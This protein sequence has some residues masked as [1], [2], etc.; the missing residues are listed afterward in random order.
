MMVK[1]LHAASRIAAVL[2][3]VG[4][5]VA[6]VLGE[7]VPSP[8]DRHDDGVS[9]VF[10]LPFTAWADCGTC[11]QGACGVGRHKFIKGGGPDRAYGESTHECAPDYCS[12]AHPETAS[13]AATFAALPPESQ[14]QIW[15][16]LAVAQRAD[17]LA[18]ELRNVLTY[19][20]ARQAWQA[21]NC[22]GEVIINIPE[23]ALNSATGE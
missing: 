3:L 8:L 7:P 10:L 1:G 22:Q 12:V 16:V 15:R 4:G 20:A 11:N 6:P 14:D 13:C 19:N 23:N 18:P 9:P 2:L 5:W 21:L 17:L